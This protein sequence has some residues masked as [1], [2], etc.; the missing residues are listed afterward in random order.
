[1][2]IRTRI[3]VISAVAVLAAAVV[4]WYATAPQIAQTL[5]DRAREH[6]EQLVIYTRKLVDVYFGDIQQVLGNLAADP[7]VVG[8]LQG[9]SGLGSTV[10][11]KLSAG[12]AQSVILE[13]RS[14][15]DINCVAR[16]SSA[17]AAVGRDLSDYD[18]CQ[19][20]KNKKAGYLSSAFISP[21][22]QSPI[23]VWAEPVKTSSGDMIGFVIGTIKITRLF[24]NLVGLQV[25]GFTSVLDRYGNHF[26]GTRFPDM[27]LAKPGESVAVEVNTVGARLQAGETS[28][29]FDDG[30]DHL[31]SFRKFDDLT[32]IVG[33]P[34]ASQFAFA[35][36]ISVQTSAAMAV[37]LLLVMLV[38][39]FVAV[40]IGRRLSKLCQN[41]N[42]ISR[43]KMDTKI[44]NKSLASR[45]EIGDLARAFDRTLV[46]LKLAM[47]YGQKDCPDSEPSKPATKK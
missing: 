44:D 42:D 14:V 39:I 41:I 4:G 26:L 33:Q 38:N 19:G 15:Y 46:S 13:N 32:I 24:D 9:N 8:L 28:G 6:Q 7:E 1:M 3:I 45:D 5:N 18:F 22:T 30:V 27:K 23:L 2:T 16:A 20:V 21:V 25:G 35:R 34:S 12:L 17:A 11:D 47:R 10:N 43:G 37:T 36:K 31:V 29:F 40:S